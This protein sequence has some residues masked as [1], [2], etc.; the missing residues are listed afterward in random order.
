MPQRAKKPEKRALWPNAG[1]LGRGQA[2]K[3][4]A[5]AGATPGITHPRRKRG[6]GPGAPGHGRTSSRISP[7]CAGLDRRITAGRGVGSPRRTRGW[8]RRTSRSQDA[9][10]LR[11]PGT[12]PRRQCPASPTPGHRDRGSPRRARLASTPRRT[13]GWPNRTARGWGQAGPG[14]QT[15]TRHGARHGEQHRA[16]PGK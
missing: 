16:A 4:G 7:P 8:P 12:I 2:R 1:V 5:A 3:N 9:H 11:P 14:G 15:A 13:R 10:S 6:D